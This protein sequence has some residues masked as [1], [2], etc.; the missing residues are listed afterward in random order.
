M[1]YED[2]DAKTRKVFGRVVGCRLPCYNGLYE[3]IFRPFEK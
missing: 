3:Y 2:F 1:L